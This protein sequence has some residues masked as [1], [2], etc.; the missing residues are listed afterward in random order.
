V[1]HHIKKITLKWIGFLLLT[2]SLLLLFFI[3]YKFDR[4][5]K[6]KSECLKEKTDYRKLIC[7][8]PYFESLTMQFGATRAMEKA[9][10]LKKDGIGNTCHIP[11]HYIGNA[12][13]KKNNNNLDDAFFSCPQ[14][15]N[16]GCQHGVLEQ[17]V[18]DFVDLENLDSLI[19]K[20]NSFKKDSIWL[21][22]QCFHG[23]GHGFI[24]KGISIL[25]S[26]DY[27]KKNT[28]NELDLKGCL[29]GVAM[30]RLH[31]FL[32]LEEKELFAKVPTIC[33]M[34]FGS[35]DKTVMNT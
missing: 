35:S 26:Y 27:C 8:K 20:C 30:E 4:L 5:D 31:P 18:M 28:T 6:I 16:E 32:L 12:N 24:R 10:E 15:C 2:I 13:L 21:S 19:E 25:G 3:N 29:G 9:I 14:T 17:Y 1:L 11:S 33:E 23:L 22:R 34:E 7:L